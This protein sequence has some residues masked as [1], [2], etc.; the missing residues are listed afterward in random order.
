MRLGAHLVIGDVADE[1]LGEC[2]LQV[3]SVYY[4]CQHLIVVLLLHR[5]LPANQRG[6][7]SQGVTAEQL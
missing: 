6:R 7:S 4:V 2:E 1:S 5:Q 3:L